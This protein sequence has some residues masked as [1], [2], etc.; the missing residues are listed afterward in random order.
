MPSNATIAPPYPGPPTAI[1]SVIESGTPGRSDKNAALRIALY[2]HDT[3]GLGHFRRNLRIAKALRQAYPNASLLLI[4][5]T[6]MSQ[7]FKRTPGIDLLNLPALYKNTDGSYHAR[8]LDMPLE[9]LTELRAQTIRSALLAFQTDVLIVD[10]VPRGAQNELDGLLPE[11]RRKLGT[12]C[13]LGLRDI[14]DAPLAARRE[15]LRKRCEFTIQ[16]NYHA[17]WVYGDPEV[18]DLAEEY[19]L[20]PATRAMM[21]FTGYLDARSQDSAAHLSEAS[22]HSMAPNKHL[23]LCML[24]G[25]QDGAH[26]ADAFARSSLPE[27]TNALLL[28]G[29]DFPVAHGHELKSL[30][31]Q[32]PR[33]E[34]L[35]FTSTPLAL[36][37]HADKIIA[38]G[39]YNTVY[40]LLSQGKRPLIVP[41]VK[42]R[43]EQLVRAER[44]QALGMV[45]VLLPDQ[46]DTAHLS[47]WLAK[48]LE[49]QTAR[50]TIDFNGLE[51]LPQLLAELL[52]TSSDRV[53]PLQMDVTS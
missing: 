16:Q 1:K 6:R 41:R 23:A 9:A 8:Y 39:G 24:G 43:Q 13:V 35:D 21:R 34:I 49:P 42:P 25:G 29:P 40:E 48:P 45:D 20:T 37:D 11:L 27:D 52:D 51:R 33:L 36:I 10:N 31:A 3:M 30:A 17:V 26:L 44:L 12:R 15:W 5:G 47:A 32:N 38:M 14:I 22:I 2:S 19:R 46:L 18:Y 50:H 4:T 28:I 53:V 7:E